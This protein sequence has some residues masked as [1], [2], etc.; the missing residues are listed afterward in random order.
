MTGHV[1]NISLGGLCAITT[2]ALTTASLVR[3]EVAVGEG[4]VRIST[5]TQ[6]RWTQPEKLREDRFMSGMSFLI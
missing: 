6:V 4:P 1:H 5:L 3:C 2:R